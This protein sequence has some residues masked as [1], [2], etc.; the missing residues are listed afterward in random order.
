MSQ[1]VSCRKSEE[2]YYNAAS[3]I[4]AVD[5]PLSDNFLPQ[6]QFQGVVKCCHGV[7]VIIRVK[8]S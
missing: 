1:K 3:L 8:A 4:L 5:L 7:T 6:Y 2:A